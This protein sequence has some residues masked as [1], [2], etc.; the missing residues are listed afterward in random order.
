[1]DS[2]RAINNRIQSKDRNDLKR[3]VGDQYAGTY[4]RPASTLHSW[5]PSVTLEEPTTQDPKI[6]SC[7]I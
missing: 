1:M 4:T 7:F 3:R 2:T 5:A 6:S